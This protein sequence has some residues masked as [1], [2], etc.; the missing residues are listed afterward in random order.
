MCPWG[1]GGGGSRSSCHT[2]GL[3]GSPPDRVS[4]GTHFHPPLFECDSRRPC[5]A[6]AAASARP[7]RG[8]LARGASLAAGPVPPTSEAGVAA[9][10]ARGPA[11]RRVHGSAG[12]A[13]LVGG[14]GGG[15]RAGEACHAIPAATSWSHQ[16]QSGWPQGSNT[17][18]RGG[19]G[20][21]NGKEREWQKM[22]HGPCQ[23]LR[24]PTGICAAGLVP[25]RGTQTAA[26]T[27]LVNPAS[28]P[29]PRPH[30]HTPP[31]APRGRFGMLHPPTLGHQGHHFSCVRLPPQLRAYAGTPTRP[32]G[33]AAGAG[34]T[35]SPPGGRAG[36]TRPPQTRHRHSQS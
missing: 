28:D 6:A 35:P 16:Q 33:S 23:V 5:G 27:P 7:P 10:A 15:G 30:Q 24:R 1:G 29:H 31:P 21:G 18:G 32:P 2:N 14:G 26:M 13:P 19:G 34:C 36:R 3:S 20:G 17:R 25:A 22:G 11:A 8:H 12:C 4:A 9:A